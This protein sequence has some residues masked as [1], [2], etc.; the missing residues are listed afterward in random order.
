MATSKKAAQAASSQ[1]PVS[2]NKSTDTSKAAVKPGKK[3]VFKYSANFNK[4][5]KREGTKSFNIFAAL[6]SAGKSA[7]A[8]K[9]IEKLDSKLG[10]T[11]YDV[12]DTLYLGMKPGFVT[13]VQA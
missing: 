9:V 1:K 8:D 10:Y 11:R 5:P 13:R 6:K 2:Q 12:T 3:I 7:T 4:N